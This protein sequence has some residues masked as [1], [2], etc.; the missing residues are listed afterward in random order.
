MSHLNAT[1]PT[2]G[3]R[4]VGNVEEYQ[5]V[6]DDPKSWKPATAAESVQ[7]KDAY[8]ILRDPRL[9][10]AAVQE[11]T[12]RGALPAGQYWTEAKAIEAAKLSGLKGAEPT[13]DFEGNITYS[14]AEYRTYVKAGRW[15]FEEA[16]NPIEDVSVERFTYRIDPGSGDLLRV[17]NIDPNRK[18]V[19][20][21]APEKPKRDRRG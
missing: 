21:S 18:D 8:D 4:L 13:E 3:H 2:M 11:G 16:A 19:V 12:E 20:S 10:L 1:I 17:S 14:A 15:S 9:A 6:Q 5:H 7:Y